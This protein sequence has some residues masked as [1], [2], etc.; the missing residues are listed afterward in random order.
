MIDYPRHPAHLTPY[1]E[2]LGAELTVRFLIALGGCDMYFPGDP[3][4]KSKAEELVGP[5]RLKRL[6]QAMPSN[7]SR[8][9]LP[10]VWLVHALQAEGRTVPETCRILKTTNVTVRNSLKKSPHGGSEPIPD[11]DCDDDRQMS[12]F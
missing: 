1:V 12:L 2:T 8:I 11:D 6:G 3:K 10:R 4:G 7:R 9:P 5:E